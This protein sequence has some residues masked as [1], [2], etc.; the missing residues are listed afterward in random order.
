MHI[1]G[2]NIIYQRF[3]ETDSIHF[4]H[5]E[6]LGEWRNHTYVQSERIAT[7]GNHRVRL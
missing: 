4:I 7:L 1:R 6:E 5:S 2:K 3:N